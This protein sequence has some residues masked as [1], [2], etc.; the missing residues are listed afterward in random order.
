[1]NNME[2]PAWGHEC[3]SFYRLSQALLTRENVFAFLVLKAKKQAGLLSD[4]QMYLQMKNPDNVLHITKGL[5]CA[6]MF[7]N[8]TDV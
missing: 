7:M 2:T 1:M 3:Q 4:K 5:T 6:C 8:T